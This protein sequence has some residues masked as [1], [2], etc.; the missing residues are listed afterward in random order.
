MKMP[1]GISIR[2]RSIDELLQS[3]AELRGARSKDASDATAALRAY[4]AASESG[5]PEKTAHARDRLVHSFTHI[6]LILR[7]DEPRS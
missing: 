3:I 6:G 2:P 1:E 7:K 4:L 5:D